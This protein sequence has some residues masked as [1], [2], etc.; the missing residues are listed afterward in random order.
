MKPG[1]MTIGMAHYYRLTLALPFLVS[2]V[3]YVLGRSAILPTLPDIVWFSMILGGMPYVLL[4]SIMFFW[5]KGKPEKAIH[6][7]IYMSP[8]IMVVLLAIAVPVFLPTLRRASAADRGV[9]DAIVRHGIF[10][11]ALGY[12]YVAAVQS[13]YLG[14]KAMRRITPV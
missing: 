3:V 14:L 9:V 6:Q 7:V 4:A 8:F 12:L 1:P 10:T 2:A 13:V 11:L 5:V